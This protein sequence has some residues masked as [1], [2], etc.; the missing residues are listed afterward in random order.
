MNKTISV[1]DNEFITKVGGG[2]Q[3]GNTN[4]ITVNLPN[5]TSLPDSCFNGCNN[6]TTLNLP[7]VTTIGGGSLALLYK[8]T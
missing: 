1:L 7:K 6:I 8:I 4:L 3:T 5:V 2:F